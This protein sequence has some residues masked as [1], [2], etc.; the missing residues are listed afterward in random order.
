MGR[1]VPI[2]LG[3]QKEGKIRKK[4]PTEQQRVQQLSLSADHG[5]R[6]VPFSQPVQRL[7]S[8]GTQCRTRGRRQDSWISQLCQGLMCSLACQDQ[9]SSPLPVNPRAQRGDL[10]Q[11]EKAAPASIFARIVVSSAQILFVGNKK[12]L[13]SNHWFSVESPSD[14]S[15]TGLLNLPAFPER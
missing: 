3:C 12:R 6:R 15:G 8:G 5:E 4:I 7:L 1:A 11:S 14:Q 13:A 9:T 10:G 2:L